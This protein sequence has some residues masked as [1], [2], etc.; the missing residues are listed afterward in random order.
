MN[1][2]EIKEVPEEYKQYQWIADRFGKVKG[3]EIVALNANR[4]G[5]NLFMTNNMTGKARKD[6]IFPLRRLFFIDYQLA[7]DC[8][9]PYSI[10]EL[11]DPGAMVEIGVAKAELFFSDQRV[12]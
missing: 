1:I 11:D 10:M 12:N 3:V 6:F 4:D 7:G 5:I 9:H 2:L 8:P